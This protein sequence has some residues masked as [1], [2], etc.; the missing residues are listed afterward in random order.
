MRL[1][2]DRVPHIF[3]LLLEYWNAGEPF[4]FGQKASGWRKTIRNQQ[5]YKSEIIT[6]DSHILIVRGLKNNPIGA[7][8]L[9]DQWRA[10]QPDFLEFIVICRFVSQ[11]DLC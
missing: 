10:S 11:A 1:M 5:L 9:N 7:I 8:T 3:G 6:K 4:K 2:V